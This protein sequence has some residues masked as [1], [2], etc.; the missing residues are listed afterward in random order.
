MLTETVDADLR[1]SGD[2]NDLQSTC[3][4]LKSENETLRAENVALNDKVKEQSIKIETLTAGG[5]E[6]E[7]KMKDSEVENVKTEMLERRKEAREK[8]VHLIDEL[9][10]KNIDSDSSGDATINMKLAEKNVSEDLGLLSKLLRN[11]PS[12]TPRTRTRIPEETAQRLQEER[13]RDQKGQ[14][15]GKANIK[16]R[17]LRPSK[18]KT[19]AIF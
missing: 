17:S 9:T 12:E 18:L 11:F 6:S 19:H 14:Y 2:S 7:R 1:Q 4:K 13:R 16:N 15:R 8:F 10:P 3:S 5:D